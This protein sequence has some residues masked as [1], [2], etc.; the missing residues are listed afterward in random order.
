MKK[1]AYLL[2]A[3]GT[4]QKEGN[5]ALWDLAARFQKAYP[6]RYV[7][8]C[9]L[10]VA[11]PA[12][13]EGIEA[14]VRQGAKE[15]FVLPLMLFQGRHVKL[16]IPAFIEEASRKFPDISFHYTSPIGDHPL[17]IE[18]LEAKARAVAPKGK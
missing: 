15:I 3:H 11:R 7:T 17:L 8:G 10:D 12:I 6:D 5:D 18:L 2:I 1:S 9:F 13:P 4:R 16:D 14:C